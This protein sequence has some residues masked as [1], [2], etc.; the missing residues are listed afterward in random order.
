MQNDPFGGF[1]DE[2]DASIKMEPYVIEEEYLFEENTTENDTEKASSHLEIG[3]VD[4]DVDL[5]MLNTAMK[6]ECV[7]S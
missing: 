5:E 2:G 1:A 6:F 4:E 3:G 7:S